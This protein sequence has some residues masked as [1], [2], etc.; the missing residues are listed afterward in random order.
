MISGC[1]IDRKEPEWV[2]KAVSYAATARRHAPDLVATA[3]LYVGVSVLAGR[4]WRFPFDDEL[5]TLAVAEWRSLKQVAEF[6]LQG[7]DI[8]PPLS[9]VLFY[10]LYHFGWSEAA[11]RLCSLSMTCISLLLFH[12]LTLSW[13]TQRSVGDIKLF[14]RLLAILLFGLSPLAIGQGDAIRW[15]PPFALLFALF[16]ISYASAKRPIAQLYSAIPLGLA[17]STNFIAAD[18]V[19][20]LII[21]RYLFQRNGF[22]AVFDVS[23][24]LLFLV[25]ALPAASWWAYAIASRKF[26]HVLGVEFGSSPLRAVATDM[27]GFFGGDALGVSQAWAVVPAIAVTGFA[28]FWLAD[29]KR[30]EHPV[31]FLLLTLV[32]MLLMVLPG[33]GEA[34][35]FLYLAPVLASILTLFF[36]R[37][38][39]RRGLATL[40]ASLVLLSAVG[41]VANINHGSTPFK[42]NAAI[43][44]QEILDFIRGNTRGHSLVVS[45]D[46]VV[47]RVLN[48]DRI[49]LDGCVSYFLQNGDCFKDDRRYDTVFAIIGH[50][51]FSDRP[52]VLQDLDAKLLAATSGKQKIAQMKAGLDRDAAIKSK[53]TG[54]PLQEYILAV[55]LYR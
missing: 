5:F 26:S 21:Y 15:Y 35:A 22:R 23:Y 34:R 17:A 45:T 32:A 43:P 29:R 52:H 46:P 44:Y 39:M 42:R 4:V 30:P 7:G 2:G 33:F 37:L 40:L 14:T 1:T 13:I 27:L 50:S 31:N 51:N 53:L 18:V 55:D 8:H 49:K 20:P 11:M 25:L 54:V 10:A 36:D 9:F 28:V 24:W 19:A 48:H 41:A 16:F 38:A 3:V 47:V 12:V 6:F